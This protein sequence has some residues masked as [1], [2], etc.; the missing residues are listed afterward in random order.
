MV[1]C[2]AGGGSAAPR[3]PATCAGV[4]SA[5]FG[6]GMMVAVILE[7]VSCSGTCGRVTMF[8]R[9]LVWPS[10]GPKYGCG[11]LKQ[12]LLELDGQ[13]QFSGWECHAEPTEVPA[14]REDYWPEVQE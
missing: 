5:E 11:C 14:S 4:I 3:E 1:R 10:C 13:L 9:I 12:I 8:V 7:S 2:V 6:G